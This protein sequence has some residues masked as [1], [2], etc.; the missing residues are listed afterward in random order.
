MKTHFN[1]GNECHKNGNDNVS[2]VKKGNKIK[3]ACMILKQNSSF[4]CL[5]KSTDGALRC[6]LNAENQ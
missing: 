2:Y 3:N 4:V 5:P 1:A 6:N